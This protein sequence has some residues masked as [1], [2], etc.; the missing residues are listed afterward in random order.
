MIDGRVWGGIKKPGPIVDGHNLYDLHH[1]HALKLNKIAIKQWAYLREN[2]NT[3]STDLREM[4]TAIG[5]ENCFKFSKHIVIR[6]FI[7]ALQNKDECLKNQIS[8]FNDII[9]T[10][11][12]SSNLQLYFS[13][14]TTN[15]TKIQDII[16]CIDKDVLSRND[17]A[18]NNDYLDVLSKIRS[19]S[20]YLIPSLN[21]CLNIFTNSLNN[22]IISTTNEIKS[23]IKIQ[24][25]TKNSTEINTTS[26]N[27]ETIEIDIDNCKTLNGLNEIQKNIIEIIKSTH[28]N[29]LREISR[30]NVANYEDFVD[31]SNKDEEKNVNCCLT[32]A[33]KDISSAIEKT[34]SD[35]NQCYVRQSLDFEKFV[36]STIKDNNIM[37][38]FGNCYQGNPT[39]EYILECIDMIKNKNEKYNNLYQTTMKLFKLHIDSEFSSVDKCLQEEMNELRKSVTFT[40]IKFDNCINNQPHKDSCNE[41]SFSLSIYDIEN[42]LNDNTDREFIVRKFV[43][44][45]SFRVPRLG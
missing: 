39:T 12:Q 5:S 11:I 29:Y 25:I 17:E 32:L 33:V 4:T 18:I 31:V 27:N 14:C 30:D 3:I 24:P 16:N 34:L 43:E 21:D 41:D 9:Q 44:K 20:T 26:Q 10:K 35:S 42:L 40:N 23:C 6:G 8:S 7:R 36:Q 37:S 15:K 22:S 1:N 2:Y 19:E 28:W 38:S 45:L 13:Y